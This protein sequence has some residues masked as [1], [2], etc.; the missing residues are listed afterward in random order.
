M[1]KYSNY[2]LGDYERVTDTHVYFWG[3]CFS[4]WAKSNFTDDETKKHFDSCEKYMMYNKAKLFDKS[5]CDPILKCNDPKEIKKMGKQ[6]KN[7]DQVVWDEHK[8]KIVVRGNYLK[9]AQDEQLKSVLIS[10][11]DRIFVEASPYDKIWGVGLYE[12]DDNILD[13]KNW[14]GE[15]LLGKAITDVS[16]MIRV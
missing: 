2:K 4:Q 8:Y 14:A 10:A 15:N 9:F 3:G 16:K 5:F 12:D 13:E 11:G 6:I 7:F 1:Y